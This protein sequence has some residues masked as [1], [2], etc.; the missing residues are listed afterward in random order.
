MRKWSLELSSRRIP[1]GQDRREDANGALSDR[2]GRKP[3]TVLGL[4]DVLQ[5]GTT[6]ATF[7]AHVRFA[8]TAIS[9]NVA[10][11]AFGGTAPL[12]NESLIEV[13]GDRLWPAYSMIAASA[14]GMIA[15]CF[16]IETRGT[17]LKGREVPG[18]AEHR[19]T[20]EAKAEA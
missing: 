3:F 7:P 5:L 2:I 4:V 11:A 9:Y 1:F 6:S 8:G 18:L 20:P 14:I 15:L 10:T 17:S 13:T 12:I 16:V 19:T